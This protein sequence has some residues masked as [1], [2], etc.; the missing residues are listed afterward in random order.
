MDTLNDG[1]IAGTLYNL[2]DNLFRTYFIDCIATKFNFNYAGNKFM[3]K[4][5]FLF[6]II[7]ENIQ[8]IRSSLY[9]FLR[10][11]TS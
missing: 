9:K 2:E 11:I 1:N 5:G 6:I 7:F 4:Y 8:F 10:F 3:S